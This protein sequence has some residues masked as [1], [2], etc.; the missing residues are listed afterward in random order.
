MAQQGDSAKVSQLGTPL[1]DFICFG[2]RFDA[3]LSGFGI[4]VSLGGDTWGD[5]WVLCSEGVL[6]GSRCC[7][8]SYK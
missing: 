8:S 6:K 1:V 4:L 5:F 7:S 3:V 2:L